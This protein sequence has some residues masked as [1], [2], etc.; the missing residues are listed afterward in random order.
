MSEQL[1]DVKGAMAILRRFSRALVAFVLVGVAATAAYEFARPAQFHATALV[2][3][4]ET[5]GAGVQA[6]T[7]NTITTDAGVATSAAVLVPAGHRAA[8]SLSP[9]ALADSVTATV[10]TGGV[11]AIGATRPEAGQAESL[12]NAV[13]RQLV[14]FVTTGGL[15]AS[16][17]VVAGLQAEST[18][19][20]H[21]L[22]GVQQAL[23]GAQHRLS[24]DAATSPAAKRDGA[25]ATA[26]TSQQTTIT[27]ELNSVKSQIAQAELSQ[28]AVN[29]GTEVIQRA[30]T[31]VGRSVGWVVLA[32]ALGAVGGLL[33]G[34]IWLLARHRK[35]SKLW[36]RDGIADVV[37]APVVLSLEVPPRRAGRDWTAL[38]E[39]VR[40]GASECWHVQRALREL[41]VLGGGR[42]VVVSFH[43]DA[44]GISQALEM[45]VAAASSGFET[46]VCVVAEDQHV[47]ALQ[48]TCARLAAHGAVVRPNLQVHASLPAPGPASAISVVAVV[49]DRHQPKLAMI[50]RRGATTILS[51]SAGAAT[52]EDLARFAIAAA[53]SGDPVEALFV[54]NPIPGDLTTGRSTAAGW[55][56]LAA[57]AQRETPPLPP[58]AHAGDKVAS[59]AS[60]NGR[61]RNGASATTTR[62]EATR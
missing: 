21:Q 4:P 29:Q 16:S 58:N 5:G 14:T 54:A 41:G 19:L 45:V 32:L 38:F 23:T 55:S 31:A 7:R 59:A 25:L 33:V 56:V 47:P 39:R 30:R 27:L 40:P 18:D 44:P 17:R 13:A 1:L 53:D 12:A 51:V 43:D 35:D 36:T 50:D 62:T 37:G 2:L 34:S 15:A 46:S 48:Q 49:V 24:T 61:R 3:L 20:S 28:I 42:L 8:P 26:L 9:S 6:A 60:R 22:A 52:A 11:L 57:R 10:E